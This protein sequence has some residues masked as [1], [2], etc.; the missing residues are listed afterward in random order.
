MQ[1]YDTLCMAFK[2]GFDS[3][4]WYNATGPMVLYRQLDALN[5][6]PMR[7]DSAG[8]AP[9]HHPKLLLIVFFFFFFFFFVFFFLFDGKRYHFPGI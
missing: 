4:R 1:V 8:E 7:K 5:P 2:C 9:L 3:I 6:F